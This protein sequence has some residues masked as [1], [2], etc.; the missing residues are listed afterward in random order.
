MLT[1]CGDAIFMHLSILGIIEN[2]YVA[3]GVCMR[4]IFFYMV[5]IVV[6]DVCAS[7]ILRIPTPK[8]VSRDVFFEILAGFLNKRIDGKVTSQIIP[9]HQKL[10]IEATHQKNK[11]SLEFSTKTQNDGEDYSIKQPEDSIFIHEGAYMRPEEISARI[12]SSDLPY[13]QKCKFAQ[14]FH[15]MKSGYIWSKKNKLYMKYESDD[16]FD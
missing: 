9:Y 1:Q 6:Q 14:I 2:L 7:S 8:H 5:M 12:A 11:Y 4:M 15:G 3:K 10:L 16:L 13:K